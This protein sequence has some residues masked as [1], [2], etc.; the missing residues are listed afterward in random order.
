MADKPAA[1]Q[2]GIYL[3]A[4]FV[5]V[6]GIFTYWSFSYNKDLIRRNAESEAKRISA[7]IIG[8]VKEKMIPVEEITVTLSQQLSHQHEDSDFLKI[9][10]NLL[11]RIN[12]ITSIQVLIKKQNSSD[13]P[14]LYYSNR[15]K[16]TIISDKIFEQKWFCQAMN[17]VV[18]ELEKTNM[19]VWSEPYMCPKDSQLVVLYFLPYTIKLDD[20]NS[21]VKGHII[22][23][24]SLDFLNN[25]INE[26]KIGENGFAFLISD[27]GTFIT[28]PN[29][30]FILNRTLYNLPSRVF[31]GELS[32][33][34]NILKSDFGSVTVY[35]D[36]L[37]NARSL[38]FHTK[39]ENTGWVLSTVFPKNELNSE[40]YWLLIRMIV[41]I[42]LL[43]TGIFLT[44]FYI[45]KRI[46]KPLSEVAH[47]IHSFSSENHEYEI[48]I[49]N[50]A[51]ALSNSLKRLRKTYEK[52]RMNEAQSLLQSQKI[53]RELLMASE[54]QKSIIPPQGHWSLIES[55]ISLY[56]VFRPVNMVSGDL[57]DFFMIDDKHFLITI[58]DVSGSGVP[59]AL[60][61]GVAHTFIKNYSKGNNA[62]EIVK[63]VNIEM[64]RNNSNQYFITLF[65][66]ILNVE[67][68]TF[69]YC[70][71]GHAPAYHIRKNGKMEILT[72][73]HGLP[74]GLFQER[75]Y[76]E[77]T[78]HLVKGDKLVLYTDGVTDQTNESGEHF[79]EEHFRNIV[80]LNRHEK[81]EIL[82]E[83]L[84]KNIVQ[85]SGK[86]TNQDDLSLLIFQFDGSQKSNS[87]SLTG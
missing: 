18:S 30:E 23:E 86:S 87:V 83:R 4:L 74:L 73:T 61:M 46:M 36:P 57:Y 37:N 79:G 48:Q 28:H 13:Q 56:S 15:V 32:E 9:L 11:E 49:R 26:T 62:K 53:E 66:G 44:V 85:F 47:Q 51:E 60:F 1:Y 34:D 72:K 45:S 75:I 39:I 70:N 20:Q 78:I 50:E 27:K 52:F 21:D 29:K 43:L 19:A 6:F 58:G 67:E 41:L 7:Q 16:D 10:E 2:L 69:N 42:A 77:S 38:A 84:M 8:T 80:K 31:R 25:L 22:S 76:E 17:N 5:I 3:S 82:A 63:K 65:L 24:I 81:P 71:A 14:T 68:G 40:L 64:C 59:A 35:P 12:Y 33:L 55:G 54:I